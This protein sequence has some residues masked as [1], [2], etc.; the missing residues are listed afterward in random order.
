[1][2][3][4]ALFAGIAFLLEKRRSELATGRVRPTGGPAWH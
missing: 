1:M 4:Y 2:I 3:L